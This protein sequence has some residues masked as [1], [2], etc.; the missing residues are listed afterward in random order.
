MRL[1]HFM[2]PGVEVKCYEAV[3]NT[4]MNGDICDRLSN[5]AKMNA[6]LVIALHKAGVMSDGDVYNAVRAMYEPLTITEVGP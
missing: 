2:H 4:C 1:Q 3:Y 6:E 5:I